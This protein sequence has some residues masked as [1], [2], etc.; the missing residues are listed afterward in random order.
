MDLVKKKEIEGSDS[1]YNTYPYALLERLRPDVLK[2]ASAAYAQLVVE[3]PE[4]EIGMIQ[5][6]VQ[7]TLTVHWKKIA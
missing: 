2:D 6:S 7:K 3:H 5:D 4:Y 1:G